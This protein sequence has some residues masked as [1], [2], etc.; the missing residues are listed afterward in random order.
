VH[1]IANG[2]AQSVTQI[3]TQL[4]R[5][6]DRVHEALLRAGRDAGETKILAV[7]KRQPA[8]AIEAA[9]HAGQTHFAESYV[10]E[11]LPKMERLSHLAIDWHFI[12]RIQSNKTRPIA[13]R[14]Q[15]AHTV[16]RLKL[17]VRLDSQRP[18]RAPPL[19]V[20]IQVNQANEPQKGGIGE[21]QAGD[22]AKAVVALPHLRL[23][24]LM[25]IPPAGLC[26]DDTAACFRRLRS[27][28]S[29]LE[30]EGIELEDLSMGMSADF[31]LAIAEGA[32]WVRLGTAIFGPR[33]R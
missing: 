9:F 7:S 24:G 31:E 32:T 30:Q 12:G 22:L 2:P 3:T 16:D 4:A 6:R 19:N 15:W 14:F 17:A 33:S 13:E 11:A 20:L 18:H 21:S 28:K 29:R 26:A 1:S 10:A 5:A 23:R 27:L 25:S 8:E